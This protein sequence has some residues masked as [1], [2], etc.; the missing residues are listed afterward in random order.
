M[1]RKPAK[2][3]YVVVSTAKVIYVAFT[4][5]FKQ[6]KLVVQNMSYIEM[7]AFPISARSKLG[8]W[9]RKNAEGL[10]Q[11]PETLRRYGTIVSDTAIDELIT[12]VRSI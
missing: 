10:G 4:D 2:F 12:Q 1:K 3:Y 11:L 5:S 9:Y 8:K 7:G 6:R